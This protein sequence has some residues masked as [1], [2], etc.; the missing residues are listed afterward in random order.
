[1][2]AFLLLAV[3][4]SAIATIFGVESRRPRL[5]YAV[6]PL[7]M[8][9]ILANAWLSRTSAGNEYSTG[10]LA[11]LAV[12]LV[13]DIFLMLPGDRF[14]PGL[15]AFVVAHLAYIYA[16]STRLAGPPSLLSA[17]PLI[18]LVAIAGNPVAP[19][20]PRDRVP[21]WLYTV[22]ITFMVW[23]SFNV[24][25]QSATDESARAL[26]GAGLFFASDATLAFRRFRRDFRGAHTLVLA[27]YFTGQ[28]LIS[29]SLAR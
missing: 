9:L 12:S 25:L 14:T 28:L 8:A 13:G 10:V 24:W 29:T 2:N 7:T 27:T 4:I 26:A 18:L 3:G 16:F 5:V 19:T 23:M 1:M 22:V 17:V 11:G 21:V 6:K 15:I 20:P